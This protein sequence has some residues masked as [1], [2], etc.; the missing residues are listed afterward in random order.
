MIIFIIFTGMRNA[1]VARNGFEQGSFFKL[2]F[3]N[4]ILDLLIQPTNQIKFLHSCYCKK[5]FA[6]NPD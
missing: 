2:L 5:P 3:Q 4:K 6:S 1:L